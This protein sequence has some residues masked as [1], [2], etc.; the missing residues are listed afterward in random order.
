[1]I[2]KSFPDIIFCYKVSC[3][4]CRILPVGYMIPNMFYCLFSLSEFDVCQRNGSFQMSLEIMTA[5]TVLPSL[6]TVNMEK[7]GKQYNGKRK[8]DKRTNNYL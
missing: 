7:N 2:N 6:A 1:M 5:I 8:K 4:V 3:D